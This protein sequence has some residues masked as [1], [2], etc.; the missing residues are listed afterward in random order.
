[1]LYL[2]DYPPMY[3]NWADSDDWYFICG[4][5]SDVY[6]LVRLRRLIFL[7]WTTLRSLL[8]FSGCDTIHGVPSVHRAKNQSLSSQRRLRMGTKNKGFHR[9]SEEG[10]LGKLDFSGLGGVLETSFG[11]IT[12][13]DVGIPPTLVYSYFCGLIST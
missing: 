7:V 3:I 12:L 11:S 5:P 9:R 8:L 10:D 1:M 13:Q 6:Q 4:L 2:V